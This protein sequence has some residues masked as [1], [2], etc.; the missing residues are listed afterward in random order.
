MIITVTMN[1]AIDKTVDL[2]HMVH[3]G[4]NR[5]INVIIDE[6]VKGINVSNKIKEIGGETIA[7]VL[8]GGVGGILI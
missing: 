6:G 4:L 8:I 5:V 1:P 3:G 7:T 2:G